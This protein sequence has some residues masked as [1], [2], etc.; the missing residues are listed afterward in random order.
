MLYG[1]KTLYTLSDLRTAD[2][3]HVVEYLGIAGLKLKTPFKDLPFPQ[4]MSH[5]QF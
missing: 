4:M 5:S 1:L 3:S 2:T